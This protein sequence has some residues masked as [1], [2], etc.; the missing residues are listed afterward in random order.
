MAK[1]LSYWAENIVGYLFDH[2]W[3]KPKVKMNSI[4]QGTVHFT[5]VSQPV[6]SKTD[7]VEQSLMENLRHASSSALQQ[8]AGTGDDGNS[9]RTYWNNTIEKQ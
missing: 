9:R 6:K 8:D 3:G 1:V 2:W 7:P 5:E 4:L